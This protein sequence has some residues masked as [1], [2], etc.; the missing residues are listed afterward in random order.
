MHNIEVKNNV[1]DTYVADL[2]SLLVALLSNDAYT[3]LQSKD[4]AYD[5]L[6]N[7][8]S[9]IKESID[10]ILMYT[11]YYDNNYKNV[12]NIINIVSIRQALYRAIPTILFSGD[13]TSINFDESAV[14]NI[15]SSLASGFGFNISNLLRFS[16]SLKYF[17]NTISVFYSDQ[18]GTLKG[19]HNLV[20]LFSNIES[21]IVSV[22]INTYK[23]NQRLTVFSNQNGVLDTLKG[24]YIITNANTFYND[25]ASDETNIFSLTDGNLPLNIFSIKLD[26]SAGR[27]FYAFINKVLENPQSYETMFIEFYGVSFTVFEASAVLMLLNLIVIN[28]WNSILSHTIPHLHTRYV[29]DKADTELAVRF[30]MKV[31]L[32]RLPTMYSLYVHT[33]KELSRYIVSNLD[34]LA[35]GTAEEFYNA[36]LMY[37]VDENLDRP[38]TFQTDMINILDVLF[39]IVQKVYLYGVHVIGITTRKDIILKLLELSLENIKVATY[40]ATIDQLLNDNLITYEDLLYMMYDLAVLVENEVGVVDELSIYILML[41]M[42]T[43][44]EFIDFLRR[45]FLY[46]KPVYL[47]STPEILLTIDDMKTE[48]I[49]IT[50]KCTI[51]YEPCLYSR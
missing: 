45:I 2:A 15:V 1:I 46:N 42:C 44:T 22:S 7:Q 25:Y 28:K 18:K 39:S 31:L 37:V 33:I 36:C 35:T 24:D 40:V 5:I 4:A 9:K 48:N 29:Y 6:Q 23:D 34:I 27:E 32:R 30:F 43:T 11:P 3:K 19:V 12:Q 17:V 50:D 8:F 47:H 16:P 41:Q 14:E 20:K 13:T 26:Q 10:E 49:A 21:N 38:S 51:A